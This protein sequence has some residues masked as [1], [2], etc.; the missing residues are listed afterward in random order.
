[1]LKKQY[2]LG[3]SNTDELENINYLKLGY[4]QI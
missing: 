4:L 2:M 3:P 1:M